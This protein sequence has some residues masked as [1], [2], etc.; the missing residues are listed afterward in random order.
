MRHLSKDSAKL[1][2][3]FEL[4][5]NMTQKNSPK[6]CIY[7]KKAVPLHPQRFSNTFPAGCRRRNKDGDIQTFIDVVCD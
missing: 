1:Q 2:Q 4:C 3:K 6:S 5:N 7:Q